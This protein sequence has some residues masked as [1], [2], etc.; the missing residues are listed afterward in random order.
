MLFRVSLDSSLH[1]HRDTTMSRR[2]LCLWLPPRN[3]GYRLSLL[4]L[5][6]S[7]RSLKSTITVN[8]PRSRSVNSHFNQGHRTRFQVYSLAAGGIF[9]LTGKLSPWLLFEIS[10]LAKSCGVNDWPIVNRRESKTRSRANDRPSRYERSAFLRVTSSG[11][12]NPLRHDNGA[13][14]NGAQ[15]RRYCT[16]FFWYNDLGICILEVSHR[17]SQK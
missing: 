17:N 14:S 6:D 2:T 1:D 5:H 16:E 12:V 7:E 11:T 3:S 8:E 9:T 15:F 10:F 4:K 13:L